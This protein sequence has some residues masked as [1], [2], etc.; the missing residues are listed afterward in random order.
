MQTY[1]QK[2]IREDA[3]KLGMIGRYDPR[4]VEA[5]IRIANDTLGGLTPSQFKREI[6]IAA[7]CIDEGGIDAAE[8][9]AQSFGL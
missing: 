5:Y 8:R 4:H 6:K 7:A 1:W 2:A 9:C 3:A